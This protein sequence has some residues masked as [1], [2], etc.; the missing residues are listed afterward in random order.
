MANTANNTKL[1]KWVIGD[2]CYSFDLGR[3]HKEHIWGDFLDE[4]D[5]FSG[6][7]PSVGS[8]GDEKVKIFAH[9]T[10]HGDGCYRDRENRKYPVDAGLIGAMT[11]ETAV[12]V[13]GLASG[14]EY[15]EKVSGVHIHELNVTEDEMTLTYG[16]GLFNFSHCVHID[17]DPDEEEDEY[18]WDWD[19]E[20][21]DDWDWD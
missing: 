21:E 14:E 2:P 11:L 16:D 19:E 10:A 9:N 3:T 7:S 12:L 6:D 15:L 1:T 17:T 5:F 4:V 13:S 18:D 8:V 20:E